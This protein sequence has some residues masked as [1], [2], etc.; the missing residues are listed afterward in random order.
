[1]LPA[2]IKTE[3]LNLRPYNLQDAGHI[4]TIATDPEWARYLPV[5]Q[6]YTMADAEQF[7]ASQVLLDRER[8]SSWAIEQNKAIIGGINIRFDFDNYVGEIVSST[9]EI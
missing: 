7:I 3:R 5:P 9:G 1:M 6:P 2:V 4:L 8:H